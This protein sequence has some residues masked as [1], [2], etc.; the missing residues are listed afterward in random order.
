MNTINQT[1]QRVLFILHMRLF[2]PIAMKK[3]ASIN[4]FYQHGYRYWVCHANK[5]GTTGIY[6]WYERAKHWNAIARQF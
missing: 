2:M 6:V 5:F 1:F 3:Y 4:R